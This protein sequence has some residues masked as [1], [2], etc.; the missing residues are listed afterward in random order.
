VGYRFNAQKKAQQLGLTG[1]V[2]NKPDQSVVIVIQGQ[3]E[4]IKK[5]INWSKKGPQNSQVNKVKV[6]DEPLQEI[7]N[8]FFIK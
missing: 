7:F 6:K 1:W 2:K 4:K 8:N 5:F 3:E